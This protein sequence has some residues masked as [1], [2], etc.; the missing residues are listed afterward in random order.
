MRILTTALILSMS[1]FVS[2]GYAMRCGT[3]LINEGDSA[4][5]MLELCGTPSQD[6][7][8]N[9]TY[10]NKDGDGMNYY[11]HVNGAG[12]IDSVSASRGD[13]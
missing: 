1:L 9:I 12:M 3:H 6:T 2:G 13:L 11:I 7:Y 5:R 4:T 10:I 8:S